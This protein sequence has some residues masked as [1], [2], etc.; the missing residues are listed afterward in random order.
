M[1]YKFTIVLSQS[2]FACSKLTMKILQQGVFIVNFEHILGLVLVF[3][4]LTLNMQLAPGFAL[5]CTSMLH[6]GLC[7]G[8]V[9]EPEAYSELSQISK[10]E[11]SKKVVDRSQ[12]LNNFTK[13]S[14]LDISVSMNAPLLVVSFHK[15]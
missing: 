1:P 2:K 12:L 8:C 13:V 4:L 11:L 6:T 3:L 7:P 15:N 14:I 10:K 5:P 9:G